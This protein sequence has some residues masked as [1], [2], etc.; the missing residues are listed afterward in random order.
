YRLYV[1]EELGAIIIKTTPPYII[2]AINESN[3]TAAFWDYLTLLHNETRM[4]KKTV[5]KQLQKIVNAL[6]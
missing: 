6:T 2:F 5:I 3:L 1:K 4:D